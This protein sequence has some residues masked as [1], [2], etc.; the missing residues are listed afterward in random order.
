MTCLHCEKINERDFP[1]CSDCESTCHF[2]NRQDCRCIACEDARE[3]AKLPAVLQER[4]RDTVLIATSDDEPGTV[5][6]PFRF[7]YLRPEARLEIAR[8]LSDMISSL[9]KAA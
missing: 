7:E 2:T 9:A 8:G 4:F 5:R 3:L 6:V 1:V